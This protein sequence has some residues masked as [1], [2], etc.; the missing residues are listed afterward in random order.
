MVDDREYILESGFRNQCRA[1]PIMNRESRRDWALLA[2]GLASMAWASNPRVLFVFEQVRFGTLVRVFI[3][4][5]EK[6]APSHCMLRVAIA[7]N[8]LIRQAM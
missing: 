2:L 4:L 7:R 5:L 6:H 8:R 3:P 1:N